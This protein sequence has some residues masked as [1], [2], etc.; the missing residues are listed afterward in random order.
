MFD[1]KF[2][3]GLNR[4]SAASLEAFSTQFYFMPKELLYAQIYEL[5]D[6]KQLARKHYTSARVLLEARIIEHPEDSRFYSSL[7]MVYA[8]Q[9]K[10][11][12][13][14]QA[15]EKAVELLSVSKEAYR[16]TFRLKDL[17]LVYTM[18]GEYDQALDK[19]EYLLSIP[20]EMSL[21]L[22]QLD[23]RWAP[24]KGSPRFQRLIEK[25]K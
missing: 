6:E 16:G 23:P 1:G 17:A 11:Q 5:M 22:L 3:D 7:G 15:A 24:L 13:A 21:P 8:G 14:I 10:K 19:I 12:N 9:G 20:G 4:L 18:V 25:T 2:E